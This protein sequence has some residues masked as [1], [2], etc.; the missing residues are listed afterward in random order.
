MTSFFRQPIPDRA[1]Q[2]RSSGGALYLV[3]IA[4]G[5]FAEAGVRNRLIVSGDAAATA[6]NL[7]SMEP[8]W[9]LGITS[10]ILALVCIIALAMIYFVLLRPVSKEI[11]LLA[12]FLR[13][14][15]IT[16]QAVATLNLVAALFPLGNA[17]YLQ[18]FTPA[19]LNAL[20][21]LAIKSHSHG[22]GLALLFFGFCFLFH[23]YL[24]F[25]SGFLPKVLGILIQVAGLCY[26]TNSFALFLAPAFADSLF[27]VILAPAFVGELSLS[28]W[29]LLKGV[30]AEKWNQANAQAARGAAIKV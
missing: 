5:I 6:A 11:N 12:T 3:C 4:L 25:K 8:L 28:L 1:G 16:V 18:A 23:G 22:F 26:V 29:L 27:P 10:E 24:I 15:G 14:V 2:F 7:T 19:Q 30:N 13:M 20:A 9:R 21:S 17:A